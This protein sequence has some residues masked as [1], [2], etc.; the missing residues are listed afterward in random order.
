MIGKKSI[1]PAGKV[2]LGNE[3]LFL[4]DSLVLHGQYGIADEDYAGDFPVLGTNHYL[5]CSNRLWLKRFLYLSDLST[6]TK[7]TDFKVRTH[8]ISQPAIKE[9]SNNSF[10]DTVW[11]FILIW[12]VLNRKGVRSVWLAISRKRSKVQFY[13]SFL[14]WEQSGHNQPHCTKVYFPSFRILS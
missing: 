3:M 11:A 9:I 5:Q 13:S 2:H 7:G 12:C 8:S 10:I 6:G 14:N 4:G 1:F